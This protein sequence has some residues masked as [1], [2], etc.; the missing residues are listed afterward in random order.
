MR[1]TFTVCILQEG[2]EHPTHPFAYD[3]AHVAS[4][5]MLP[6]T[7][8][9]LLVVY[10]VHASALSIVGFGQSFQGG[11]VLQDAAEHLRAGHGQQQGQRQ[12]GWWCLVQ[13]NGE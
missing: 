6:I 5:A 1:H 7:A 12:L 13:L 10:P 2:R 8:A 11:A 9:L 4:E 3:L